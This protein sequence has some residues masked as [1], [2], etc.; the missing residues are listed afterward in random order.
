MAM[1]T[2]YYCP[3]ACSMAAHVVLEETGTRYEARPVLLSAG[4]QRTE[5]YLAVNA[6][7]QVPALRVDEKVITESVAV[8]AYLGRRFPE[9]ELLPR[10]AVE[11]ARCLAMLAWIAT[12]MDPLFRRAARPERFVA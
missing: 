12:N 9:A 5:A 1:L 6:R 2:L 3:G 7:G 4:E 10:D 8:L 11:E